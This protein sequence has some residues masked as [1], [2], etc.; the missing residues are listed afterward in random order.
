[1]RALLQIIKNMVTM[2]KR[3][4]E[5]WNLDMHLN[6]KELSASLIEP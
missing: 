4:F 3:Y 2:K 6:K 5:M 1:M